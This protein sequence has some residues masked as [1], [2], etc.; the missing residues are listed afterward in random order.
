[1]SLLVEK[2]TSLDLWG[3][4]LPDDPYNRTL[5]GNVYPSDWT[6]P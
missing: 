2:P 5:V 6:N 4:V 3:K 1:M